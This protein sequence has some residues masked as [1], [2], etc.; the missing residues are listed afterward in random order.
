MGITIRTNPS[1]NKYYRVTRMVRG[2]STTKMFPVT[3]QGKI[4]AENHDALLKIKQDTVNRLEKINIYN[5]RTGKLK[6]LSL[7]VVKHKI[8]KPTIILDFSF[9]G[10]NKIFNIKKQSDIGL[11]INAV[12]E[13]W[14]NQILSPSDIYLFTENIN[15][16]K[17]KQQ[18]IS[19]Y[20]TLI[21]S[22]E[23]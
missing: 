6:G 2:I 23:G 11:A 7:F 1:G 15:I 14:H 21:K 10:V 17:I 5:Y 19:E 3:P 12:I 13:I 8:M 20:K 16:C 9:C 22:M 4:E 18:Y